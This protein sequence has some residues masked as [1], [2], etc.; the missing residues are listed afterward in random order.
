MRQGAC[1]PIAFQ[2][3]F[4]GNRYKEINL[5]FSRHPMI[6][7]EDMNVIYGDYQ[8]NNKTHFE[9]PKHLSHT[10]N[11]ILRQVFEHKL[12]AIY[13]RFFAK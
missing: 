7:Y 1:L 11:P 8:S 4:R 6:R 12:I 2:C 13:F 9:K 10:D 5:Y 3:R